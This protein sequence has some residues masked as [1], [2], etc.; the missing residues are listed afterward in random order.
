[1]ISTCILSEYVQ[2]PNCCLPFRGSKFF[3]F[4]K[5]SR[6]L[7]APG[8][9]LFVLLCYG[10][11]YDFLPS[12]ILLHIHPQESAYLLSRILMHLGGDVTV[13]VQGEACGIMP[14]ETRQGLHIHAI[15][16]GQ[17][18]EGVP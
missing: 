3:L 13:G 8:I 17:G 2:N 9:S 4:Q 16:K 18:G 5:F 15:L 14:E 11:R 12:D 1:M 6:C 10:R 7:L